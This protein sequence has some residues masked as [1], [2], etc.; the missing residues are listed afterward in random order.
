MRYATVHFND[1]SY[2]SPGKVVVPFTE[3]RIDN[4]LYSFHLEDG[5]TTL[6]TRVDLV[7]FVELHDTKTSYGQLLS[8]VDLRNAEV[9]NIREEYHKLSN[10]LRNLEI[11]IANMKPWW[12]F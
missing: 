9:R 1:A 7:K 11:R 5:K 4:G 8:L 3:F 6:V 2:S 10:E 12:K